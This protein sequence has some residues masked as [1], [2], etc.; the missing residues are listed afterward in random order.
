[1][2]N[3]KLI[4]FEELCSVPLV[5]GDDFPVTL[6]SHAILFHA[7]LLNKRGKRYRGIEMV[8]LTIDGYFHS[9]EISNFIPS[10]LPLGPKPSGANQLPYAS[11]FRN[12]NFRVAVRS[13]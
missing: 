6:D 3:L 8:R 1:M 11:T 12:W 5:A 2:D 10:A 13:W 9:S 4:A 7:E